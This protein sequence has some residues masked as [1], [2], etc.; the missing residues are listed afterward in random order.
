MYPVYAE[1]DV[2]AERLGTTRS[3][4]ARQ[5]LRQALETI[6]VKTIEQ[7]H[8]EGYARQPVKQDEFSVVESETLGRAEKK[9]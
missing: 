6:H 1:Y 7:Q 4:F 3:A 5:A 9:K 8:R 2:D